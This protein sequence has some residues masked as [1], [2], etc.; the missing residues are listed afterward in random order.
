ME[1]IDLKKTEI[2]DLTEN[3]RLKI[4]QKKLDFDSQALMAE[5]LNVQPSALSDIFRERQGYRVS[6]KIK[7][8]LDE[9]YDVNISWLE[10]GEGSIFKPNAKPRPVKVKEP[11]P[12]SEF[13]LKVYGDRLAEFRQ[14]YIHKS[15]TKASELLQISQSSL[16]YMENGKSSISFELLTKLVKDYKLNQDWL[17]NGNGTPIDKNPPKATLLTDLNALNLELTALKKHIQFVEANQNYMLKIFER[18]EKKIN[19]R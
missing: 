9:K 10:K 7:K 6:K 12:S 2:E 4:L 15:Q 5:A 19:E 3:Q 11:E 17:T 13:N 8:L 1:T 16:S 18:L 14:R